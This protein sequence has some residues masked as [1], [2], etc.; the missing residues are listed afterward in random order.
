M[1]NW[2]TRVLY[3]FVCG[4]N[5][6]C[7][8]YLLLPWYNTEEAISFVYAYT[9]HIIWVPAVLSFFCTELFIDRKKKNKIMFKE[10]WPKNA[11]FHHLYTPHMLIERTLSTIDA[12]PS[13]NTASAKQKPQMHFKNS[14]IFCES[15]IYIVWMW[16]EW[17][18]ELEMN[19]FNIG[20]KHDMIMLKMYC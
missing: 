11:V 8:N 6:C 17:S 13:S 16:M 12:R 9:T 18:M 2:K 14:C 10:C 5:N 19:W 7:E 20:Y 4:P 1:Y 3:I 15:S